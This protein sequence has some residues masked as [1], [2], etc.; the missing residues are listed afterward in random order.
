LRYNCVLDGIT[1]IGG[2]TGREGTGDGAP[3]IG[4]L[5]VVSGMYGLYGISDSIPRTDY[6]VIDI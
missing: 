2:C 4:H 6:G 1:A 5:V 3:P